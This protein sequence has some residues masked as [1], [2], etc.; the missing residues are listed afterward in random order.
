MARMRQR[1]AARELFWRRMLADWKS[2][3]LTVRAFC[4]RHQ[5][6]EPT[7]YYWRQEL[8]R[9]D[10]GVTARVESAP[11]RSPAFV[12][13]RVVGGEPIDVVVRSGQVV[14]VAA[15]FDAAHLRA[16]VAALEAPSC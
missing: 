10:R 8:A 6:A 11:T 16:V 3:G 13:V 7:F 14:R 12:P 2:S 15:G 9:R 4:R 1:S 5:L